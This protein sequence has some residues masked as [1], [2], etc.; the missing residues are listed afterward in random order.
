M[1]KI[2]ISLFVLAFVFQQ[3]SLSFAASTSEKTAIYQKFFKATGAEAQYMQMRRLIVEQFTRE[4]LRVIDQTLA[5]NGTMSAD[6]KK[7]MSRL[8]GDFMRDA[9]THML[10]DYDK[11]LPFSDLVK[12]VFIPT[13]E[14]HFTLDEIKKVTAFYQSPVGQKFVSLTPTMMHETVSRMSAM[15][16]N[17]MQEISRKVMKQEMAKFKTAFDKINKKEKK[18]QEKA[19][20]T[21]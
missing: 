1:K 21:T 9:S 11:E 10:Q 4:F 7:E 18:K 2:F 20:P 12:N 17:T 15:Y 19:K 5:K 8:T 13:Y 16:G 3:Y 6:K 14:K